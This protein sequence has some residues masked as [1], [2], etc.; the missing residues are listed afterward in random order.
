MNLVTFEVEHLQDFEAAFARAAAERFGIVLA[1]TDPFFNSHRKTLV[2]LA[3]KHAVPTMY[4]LRE[5]VI[6]G[7]LISY[8]T[9]IVAAYR[10][11]GGYAGRVAKGETRQPAGA[12]IRSL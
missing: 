1:H 8:G 5:F 3:A 2:I 12:A 9:N 4:E 7:G 10:Q 11:L 6:E